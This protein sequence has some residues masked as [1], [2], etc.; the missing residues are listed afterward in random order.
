VNYYPVTTVDS[1]D[2]TDNGNDTRSA[3]RTALATAYVRP[4]GFRRATFSGEATRQA[5]RPNKQFLKRHAGLGASHR[6]NYRG[7]AGN[8]N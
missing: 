7:E 1:T 2:G 6:S 5:A 3:L 4:F 8:P